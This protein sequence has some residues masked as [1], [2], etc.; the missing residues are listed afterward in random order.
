[1]G[2]QELAVDLLQLSLPAGV[3]EFAADLY[4]GTLQLPE[5]LR[6]HLAVHGRRRCRRRRWWG[7]IGAGVPDAGSKQV[8]AVCDQYF[9]TV[10]S[11]AVLHE[12]SQ[13]ADVADLTVLVPPRAGAACANQPR[14]SGL[15]N[16][17]GSSWL[18]Q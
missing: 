9:S 15:V 14:P 8:W 4:D 17:S 6:Q 12:A 18:M 16:I 13:L 1:L 11:P 2:R 10:H 7:A 5:A 3:G